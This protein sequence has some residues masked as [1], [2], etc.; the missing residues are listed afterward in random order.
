MLYTR[1]MDLG[2]AQQILVMIL[3][4]ALALFLVL[5][6]VIAVLTIRFI[7]TLQAI[8]D[9]AE[10]V[11]ATAQSAAEMLKNASIPMTI[12]R[13]ARSIGDMLAKRKDNQK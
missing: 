5:G 8:A 13:F 4:V 3:A 12:L 1:Y 10:N 7:K 6:I 11:V 2:T 9:R